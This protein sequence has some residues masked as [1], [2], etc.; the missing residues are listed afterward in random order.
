MGLFVKQYYNE[1]TFVVLNDIGAVSF[2]A[3]IHLID[4]FGLGNLEIADLRLEK[5]F[6]GRELDKIVTLF[7]GKIALVYEEWLNNPAT[8]TLIQGWQKIAEWKISNNIA[9]GSDCVSIYA[10]DPAE[11]LKLYNNLK[12]FQNKYPHKFEVKYF[13]NI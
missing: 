10:V 5:K 9:C 4:L 13:Y 11:S 2:L 1:G 8:G 12:A 6:T 7:K 3:D